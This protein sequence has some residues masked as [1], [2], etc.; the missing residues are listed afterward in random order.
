MNND[1]MTRCMTYS[2]DFRKKVLLVRERDGLSMQEAADRF[3]VGVASIMRWTKQLSPKRTRN[4]PRTQLPLHIL[5]KD[6]EKYSDSYLSERA[7]RLGVGKTTVWQALQK[8]N[9]T[10]KKN[11]KTPQR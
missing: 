8:L 7:C 4:K 10:Y 5:Q 11:F 6:C 2:I 9:F 3:D 1:I